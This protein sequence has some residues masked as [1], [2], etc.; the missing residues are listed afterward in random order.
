MQKN[1]INIYCCCVPENVEINRASPST[2][3]RKMDAH[4]KSKSN[5][6]DKR[7]IEDKLANYQSN[8]KINQSDEKKWNHFGY[9]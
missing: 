5:T 1:A 7:Y 8:R 4:A 6:S 3:I 2:A 9:D